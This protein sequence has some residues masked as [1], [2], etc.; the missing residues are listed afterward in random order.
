[1]TTGSF[2][3][4][5]AL[6]VLGGV[7]LIAGGSRHPS[8]NMA[9]MLAD[10]TWLPGHAL[11][12]AGFL[13]MCAGLALFG[14][15]PGVPARTRG[16]AGAAAV[17]MALDALEMMVHTLAY[18]D[19]GTAPVYASE[20]TTASPVLLTHLWMATFISPLAGVTMLM[21]IWTGMR[22][23]SLGSPWI[24][25]LGMFG[26][27]AHAAVMPL[28][29]LM[30]LL[31]FGILFPMVAFMALWFVLAGVWPRRTPRARASAFHAEPASREA[32]GA[33]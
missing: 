10:P 26:A 5:R 24:G 18:V 27:A 13:A 6:F 14:R 8:G 3:P 20:V 4:W 31:Q 32:V 33:V 12:V 9:Q 1:M 17:M 7:L 29:F 25:W 21:L 23:R 11:Q 28:L 15:E 30:G 16:W 19:A 2:R 22:E